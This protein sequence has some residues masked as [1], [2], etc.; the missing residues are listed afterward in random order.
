VWLLLARLRVSVLIGETLIGG[1][2]SRGNVSPSANQKFGIRAILLLDC[3]AAKGL[4][5]NSENYSDINSRLS[6]YVY[7]TRA[8]LL[9]T[10]RFSRMMAA[11]LKS[12]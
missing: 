2:G 8:P 6:G 5:Q 7:F 3:G 12:R 4:H 1:G 9:Q 10:I 11:K